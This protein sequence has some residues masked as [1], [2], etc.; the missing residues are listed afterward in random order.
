M[1][2]EK[3]KEAIEK[4][5][6]RVDGVRGK[7]EEATKKAMVLPLLEAL[8]YNIWDT[9]EV[10]PEYG[11]DTANIKRGQ[12]EKVD[13]ALILEGKPKI[14]IEAKPNESGLD[15]HEGQLKR[16]FNA[17]PSVSLGILT[18]GIEYRFFS[19]TK[20]SNILDDM[21]FSVIRL[22]TLEQGLEVL[23][24]L[25]KEVFSADAL[26]ELATELVYREKLVAH[27]SKEIDVG[28]E[29][30]SESF[31]RWILAQPA[32]YNGRVTANVVEQFQ[33]I[34]KNALQR[35]IKKIVRRS[36]K[37]IDDGVLQGKESQTVQANDPLEK[38]EYKRDIVTTEE[39]L[40]CF[41]ILKKQFE[42]SDLAHQIIYDPSTKKEIPIEIA[43]KDTI[44]YFSVY[45]NKP[46]WRNCR[47]SLDSTTKWIGFEIEDSL[48]KELL[49][50][51]FE[52]LKPTSLAAFRVKINTPDDLKQL[53]KLIDASFQKTIEERR[54]FLT[55]NQE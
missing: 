40:E 51:N 4:I 27:L 35:V 5:L 55:R 10:H 14:F 31:M 30:L 53:D 20:D 21:P 50:E 23:V 3:I 33:P 37:A 32:V 1:S 9:N 49:P 45:F 39:E 38:D 41:A 28:E 43:Y 13:Y 12:K 8:G 2:L 44:L 17:T 52:Q 22:D 7:G 36:I 16:Y 11:A 6:E 47:L 24:H 34:A 18:D 46:S 26:R 15:G 54:K 42:S 19:D 25:Q 29:E 48:G